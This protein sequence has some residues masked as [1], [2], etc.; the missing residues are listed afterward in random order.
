MGDIK[1]FDLSQGQARELEAHSVAIEKSLQ[2][3]IE[4]YLEAFL[5]V[6][7][8]ATEYVTGKTH[9]GRI[10]T[11]G[12][13][14]N[15]FPVIIEY[16]R[17]TNE[18]VINQG[19]YYLNWLLDHR[20]E[21]ELLV[22]KKYGQTESARIDWQSPRLLCI[23][24]DFT[25]YDQHAVQEI[26]RNIELIR[27]RRYDA[28]LLLL[29]LVNVVSVQPVKEKPTKPAAL[30]TVE[31]EPHKP[32]AQPGQYKTVSDYLAQAPQSLKDLYGLVE[33]FAMSLGDDVQKR[34]T[35]W[36]HAYR[37]F[38]NFLGVIVH[39]RENRLVLR[40][41]INPDTVTLEPGFLQDARKYDDGV[42]DLEIR[43]TNIAEFERAKPY[44]VKSYENS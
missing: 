28:N 23:A 9:G 13:D 15:G 40:L 19:L 20:A 2:T 6:R 43:I 21:F 33:A 36:Y 27:Y 42:G 35:K 5:G 31:G 30:P 37:R 38:K 7:F 39:P 17:A 29:E 18:N 14:E 4:Q 34:E 24:G 22:M 3:L 41:K 11:L 8:L 10:D 12:I 44:I 26:P 1:L 16:K 25:R 32:K